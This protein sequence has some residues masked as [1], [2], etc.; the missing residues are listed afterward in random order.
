MK[1]LSFV[2]V[3][4]CGLL[5]VPCLAIARPTA[6]LKRALTLHASFDA[7]LNADFSRGDRTLFSTPGDV[8]GL[9]NQDIKIAKGAGRFG[10]AL[11]F[12][13]KNSG[14]PY[15]KG[16]G[17]LDYSDTR[18]SATVS[19]WL[20][21]SPDTDLEPG[22]CDPVQIVG[23]DGRKGFMFLEWSKDSNP[24][25]FRFAI[26]PLFHIWNPTNV[27]WGE[28]P[29]EKRPMVQVERA[30]FSRARWTHVVFSFENIND[31]SRPQV[32]RLYIDG[33]LQGT[34][35]N[36]EL[37]FGWAADKVRLVMGAAY[38]GHLDE[39]AVFNRVLTDAE[40]RAV[41]ELENGIRDLY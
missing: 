13:K 6:A 22:Y 7:G 40:V 23:D 20:R 9:P 30:P 32:G 34:I 19:V 1:M 27:A 12:T 37:T 39:L 41:Y 36:W 29:Y 31:K 11:L 2:A 4:T 10:D 21:L 24:R 38:V 16:P 3:L 5:A 35:E 18:W 26:R 14:R 33:Q 25:H 15:F 17:V 28:I 8:V